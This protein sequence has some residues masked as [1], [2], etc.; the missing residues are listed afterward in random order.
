M[1]KIYF[2]FAG[3]C[4]AAALNPME[5]LNSGGGSTAVRGGQQERD[6]TYFL[7]LDSLFYLLRRDALLI[8]VI[9][10]LVL[11]IGLMLVKNPNKTAEGKLDILHK[12]GIGIIICSL[13]TL[14]NVLV[15]TVSWL[16]S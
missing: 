6:V 7:Q 10:V 14:L 12:L 15:A 16:F 8:L 1:G 2:C 3:A 4:A 13:V 9:A 5:I 11:L